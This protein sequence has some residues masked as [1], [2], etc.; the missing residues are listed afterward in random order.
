VGEWGSGGFREKKA[1]RME[2]PSRE[3]ESLSPSLPH[4]LP[5]T[6]SQI[7]L[8][9]SSFSSG[10]N[11]GS[12]LLFLKELFLQGVQLKAPAEDVQ[13]NIQEG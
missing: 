11:F 4:H 5:P 3:A 6:T 13:V 2:G 7:T 12:Y 1:E 10:A 9:L 8:A